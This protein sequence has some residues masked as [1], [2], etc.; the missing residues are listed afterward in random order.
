MGC[1]IHFVIEKKKGKK[2]F[3]LCTT[4]FGYRP[5]AK[6][7]DYDF[8]SKLAGV[9]GEGPEPKGIPGLCSDLTLECLGNWK[10]D[11]HSITYMMVNEFVSIWM[12]QRGDIETVVEDNK[13]V[14]LDKCLD[15]GPIA[16][17]PNHETKY[18][19]IIWFDN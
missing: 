15:L 8:F 6:D 1:D 9:R 3:G 7:R 4:D 18:R 5:H 12:K 13:Y 19:I 17:E 16:E 11:A 14:L 2:W 10:D